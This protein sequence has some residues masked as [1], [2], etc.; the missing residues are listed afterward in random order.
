M[1][2]LSS[3]VDLRPDVYD[4]AEAFSVLSPSRGMGAV[5]LSEIESYIR[6]FDVADVPRFVRLVR[7]VDVAYLEA[8]K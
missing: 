1:R 3:R 6:L 4:I 7:A 5:P 8:Q 2:S